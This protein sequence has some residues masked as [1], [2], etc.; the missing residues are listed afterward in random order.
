L[1]DLTTLLETRDKNNDLVEKFISLL[2]RQMDHRLSPNTLFGILGMFNLLSITSIV[3]D[4]LGSEIREVSGAN[5]SGNSAAQPS[6]SITDTLSSLMKTQG[7]GQPDLMS[8]LSGLAS[9]K[10]INPGLLLSLMS[11]LNSQAGQ[12]LGNTSSQGASGSQ[13]T[14]RAG[15]QPGTQDSPRNAPAA[16][17]QAESQP[18]NESG[19]VSSEEYIPSE[20]ENPEKKTPIEGGN[21]ESGFTRRKGAGERF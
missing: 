10:K 12:G 11:M 4:N 21:T 17:S 8:L 20:K 18:R 13:E 14:G 15:F 5:D 1:K 9:Q 2:D 7:Q 6:Q 16:S 19:I 3:R